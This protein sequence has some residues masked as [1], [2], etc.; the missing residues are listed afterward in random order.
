MARSCLRSVEF[1]ERLD[2]D[3][4]VALFSWGCYQPTLQELVPLLM[5]LTPPPLFNEV[6]RICLAS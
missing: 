3:C 2:G 6:S 1:A 4:D 5:D